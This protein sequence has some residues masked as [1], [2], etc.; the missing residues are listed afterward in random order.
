MLKVIFIKEPNQSY[1]L[2]KSH[3]PEFEKSSHVPSFGESANMTAKL[4]A[5]G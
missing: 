1:Y 2:T 4:H 5:S 3:M